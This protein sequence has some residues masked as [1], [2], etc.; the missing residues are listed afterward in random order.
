MCSYNFLAWRETGRL[1]FEIDCRWQGCSIHVKLGKKDKWSQWTS[2]H[3]LTWSKIPQLPQK[4]QT[5]DG[6]KPRSYCGRSP[7]KTSTVTDFH[8]PDQHPGKLRFWTQTRRFGSDDFLFHLGDF[9]G[10]SRY[11]SCQWW[12]VFLVV[13]QKPLEVVWTALKLKRGRFP[14]TSPVRCF[15][16]RKGIPPFENPAEAN[17]FAPQQKW[18]IWEDDD[19]I[20]FPF[21]SV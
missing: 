13:T 16:G 15:G 9:W 8:L 2:D 18:M 3:L 11:F 1:E 17:I 19:E 6:N 7:K 10:S 4:L 14:R 12:K 20:S 21:G 5:V